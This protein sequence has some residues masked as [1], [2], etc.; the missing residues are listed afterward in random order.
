MTVTI[1]ESI[2]KIRPG[3]LCIV[4]F[5][6]L[7]RLSTGLKFDLESGARLYKR[8]LL[9]EREFRHFYEVVVDP[10]QSL[11]FRSTVDR[12]Q[13]VELAVVPGCAGTY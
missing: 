1:C 6:R 3:R 13:T 10:V 5:H 2:S 8:P 7:A 9:K 11:V 12:A 4:R